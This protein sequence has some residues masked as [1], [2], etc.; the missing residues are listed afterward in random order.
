MRTRSTRQ[1]SWER[2]PWYDCV[3]DCVY[4][5]RSRIS[6]FFLKHYSIKAD[7]H[8]TVCFLRSALWHSGGREKVAAETT[9]LK[10]TNLC[11]QVVGDPKLCPCI[12]EKACSRT[13]TKLEPATMYGLSRPTACQLTVAAHRYMLYATRFDAAAKN[14]IHLQITASDPDA[15]GD[16]F[17]LHKVSFIY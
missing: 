6:L 11:Y 5:S 10:L 7:A 1:K 14:P 2:A 15:G 17:I 13:E 9:P 16:K 12:G 3:L 8:I 4:K